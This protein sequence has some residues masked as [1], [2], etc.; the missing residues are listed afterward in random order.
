M[1]MMITS[2]TIKGMAPWKI[3][4]ISL[5]GTAPFKINKL[6][7]KGGVTKATSHK[8][9]RITQNH[10]SSYPKAI[11]EGKMIG[12]VINIADIIS[13]NIPIM[14]YIRITLN[15]ITMGSTGRETNRFER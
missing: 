4:L 11:M 3:S 10:I 1:A 14:K 7:P 8:N 6:S 5:F 12:N 2:A 9:T 13:I 15:K